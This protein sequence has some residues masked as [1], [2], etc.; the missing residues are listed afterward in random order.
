[1]VAPH[2]DFVGK[3]AKW[4]AILLLLIGVAG[5]FAI[6]MGRHYLSTVQRAR[7]DAR[8]L[9]LAL[10]EHLRGLVSAVDGALVNLVERGVHCQPIGLL[11]QPGALEGARSSLGGIVGISVL[12]AEGR[13][14]FSTVKSAVGLSRADRPLFKQLVASPSN[15][16]AIDAPFRSTVDGRVLIPLGKRLNLDGAL[17]G[18]V[19][20]TINAD[21]LIPLYDSLNTVPSRRVWLLH[22]SE[23]MA[24][25]GTG[26]SDQ[27]LPVLPERSGDM[28]QTMPATKAL[29][30]IAH[31]RIGSTALTIATSV[32]LSTALA[33]WYKDLAIGLFMSLA[34]ASFA[35]LFN[36][37]HRREIRLRQELLIDHNRRLD[38]ALEN[39]SQGLAMFDRHQRVIIAN[40]KFAT[41]YGQRAG[42]VAPGTPL[43]K[44]IQ[45]RI[46]AG[47]YVGAT[48][49]DITQK[50]R[51]RVARQKPSFITS[52]MGD[53]RTLSVSIQPQI[54]GGWVTTHLDITERERL[55]DRLDAALNNMPQGLVMFDRDL[56][57]VLC[58]PRYLELYS[59]PKTLV[60]VGTP[61]LEILRYCI[62]NGI[63]ERDKD[64]EGMLAGALKRIDANGTGYFETRLERGR[65]Y[66]VSVRPMS[67]G[68][69]VLTHEDIT[70]RRR[71]E[72]Q[73]EHLAHH[74]PLTG[75]AN[76]ALLRQRLGENLEANLAFA[77]L[78][79][80][81]DRF[82]SINDTMGHGVGDELLRAV[83]ERLRNR[84]R[85]PDMVARLGGDEFAVLHFGDNLQASATMVAG[86]LID[87]LSAPFELE[88][89]SLTI[90]VSIGIALAPHD[91]ANA[92]QLLQ[93]ADLALYAA[94]TERRGTYTF[95]DRSMNERLLAKQVLELELRAA[96]GKNELFLE[97]Q[98][99]HDLASGRISAC[100]ALVRWEH[101][102]MGRIAPA[103]FIP[104]AEASGLIREIGQTVLGIACL[105]AAT[106]PDTVAVSVNI[107]AVQ[108]HS[109][110]IVD[111][112]RH[113]LAASGLAARR[114]E[115]EITETTVL[116]DNE[117]AQEI[118][119][120]LSEL[121]VRIVLDDFGTGYSSLS[122]LQRFPFHKIKVDR[123][124]LAAMQTNP[125]SVALM[126]TISFLGS[127]LGVVTTVEGV[128]T[129][130]QLDYLRAEMFDQAQGYY[131]GRPLRADAL[132]GKFDAQDGAIWNAA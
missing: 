93:H 23:T 118:I 35:G 84:V 119:A 14:L 11:V 73:I 91:G 26:R 107:S 60:Q 127:A 66:G 61:A 67:D 88:G 52:K 110:C 94:K 64:P 126:R 111:H 129:Q 53:G 71:I 77:V 125:T 74:D 105:E 89:R 19:V 55:K 3:H 8:G 20:A 63:Y 72:A 49:Q 34:F 22:G 81:L 121:G 92:D 95:F 132:R 28:I 2:H 39:M 90:G 50:M 116:S 62:S 58:N 130:E 87:T 30:I 1:M 57:L 48:V 38:A 96:V 80:D 75:V 10:G 17:C 106:W 128:E 78:Y 47:I 85:Q 15:E 43:S 98:P 82:K 131:L 44:I 27:K 115:L 122:Y 36:R 9:T 102:R 86:R 41:M 59:L 18:A 114:L 54:D 51:E 108:M 21:Q 4:I 109:K 13:I 100:E 31:E 70:E 76:R 7:A 46:D 45:A 25:L 113:A 123:S 83:A 112:V 65:T 101:P 103:D 16:T 32:P 104:L 24:T 99:I 117:L 29:H 79:L 69:L 33:P 56:R 68:G 37:I 120:E 97:Y 40:D 124:F 5:A 6:F 42:D 12:D